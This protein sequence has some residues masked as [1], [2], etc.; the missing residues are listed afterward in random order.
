M[1][2]TNQ[3]RLPSLQ[4][5]RPWPV[6]EPRSRLGKGSRAPTQ[7]PAAPAEEPKLPPKRQLTQPKPPPNGKNDAPNAIKAKLQSVENSLIKAK[8]SRKLFDREARGHCIYCMPSGGLA[9]GASEGEAFRGGGRGDSAAG[10]DARLGGAQEFCAQLAQHGVAA[11]G[12]GAN[13]VRLVTHL[14]VGAAD[15]DRAAEAIARA[16]GGN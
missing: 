3:L 8:R 14:D 16:A 15:I 13:R 4:R 10:A 11:I 1:A 6:L 12:M 9:A 2:T 7:A 5:Q